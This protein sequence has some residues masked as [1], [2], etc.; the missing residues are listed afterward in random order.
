MSRINTDQIASNSG[1]TT[2]LTIADNGGVTASGTVTATSYIGSGASLTSLPA[3]NLTGTVATARL[4]SGT[5][6]TG[7]FLR[8]DGSWQTAGSTSASD[9]TSGTLPTARLPA[10]SV[11]QVVSTTTTSQNSFTNTNV[12][13]YA[14]IGLSVNIT[15]KSSSS[16][17][18]ISCTI[19]I[20]TVVSS[21]SWGGVLFLNSTKIGNGANSGSRKG[22]FLKGVK[23]YP[24][25]NHSFGAMNSFLYKT[26]LTQ[27]TQV[28]FKVGGVAQGGT[29]YINR[30]TNFT[31]TT[32]IY[33]ATGSSTI[34]V[35]EVAV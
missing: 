34:S 9:L 25:P 29:G 31:N 7:N 12:D 32:S 26:S 14:D 18:L 15:P 8:G 35:M 5:A 16:Y 24:D 21:D 27:G 11:L 33:G 2:A 19:G 6:G 20:G 30:S 23:Y 3:A 22:T 4:G 10:G 28:T 17:F 1:G 13:A